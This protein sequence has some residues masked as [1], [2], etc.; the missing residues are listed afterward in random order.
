MEGKYTKHQIS[1][2]LMLTKNP[3]VCEILKTTMSGW[4]FVLPCYIC[5]TKYNMERY[6][7]GHSWNF[8]CD[9]CQ[10][11][12]WHY[13]NY[14]NECESK[15][16]FDNLCLN[17]YECKQIIKE[18]VSVTQFTSKS[19]D[20]I[21]CCEDCQYCEK[22][23][24]EEASYDINNHNTIGLIYNLG[25]CNAE[26]DR[27]IKTLKVIKDKSNKES[28][29]RLYFEIDVDSLPTHINRLNI[30]IH[31]DDS[32]KRNHDLYCQQRKIE[33]YY[34]SID[35]LKKCIARLQGRDIYTFECNQ[36]CGIY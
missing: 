5:G 24:F 14:C 15:L 17:S 21:S 26:N 28:V 29:W 32:G 23:L 36:G 2:L 22:Q 9:R 13:D 27:I 1:Q 11:N 20:E 34:S 6:V 31:M 25:A 12:E 35:D 16:H 3:L 4:E 18:F 7:T 30:Y 8:I 19:I 10:E 33:I